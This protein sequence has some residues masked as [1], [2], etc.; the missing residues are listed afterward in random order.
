MICFA[1]IGDK[2]ATKYTYI[3]QQIYFIRI[4]HSFSVSSS[5]N[6]WPL[7][8]LS[9]LGC[10]LSLFSW[11]ARIVK[12]LFKLRPSSLALLLIVALLLLVILLLLSPLSLL[13]VYV[14]FLKMNSAICW[15]LKGFCEMLLGDIN[16]QFRDRFRFYHSNSEVNLLHINNQYLIYTKQTKPNKTKQNN[17]I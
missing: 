5:S 10:S 17:I 7:L 9:Q 15:P 14:R 13:N 8:S 6:S 12:G 3:R 16:E 1:N 2:K 4:T 11:L